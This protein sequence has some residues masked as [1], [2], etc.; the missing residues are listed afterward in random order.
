[1]P[2]IEQQTSPDGGNAATG[3]VFVGIVLT[4]LFAGGIGAVVA[5]RPGEQATSPAPGAD[6]A[7]PGRASQASAATPSLRRAASAGLAELVG[8]RD[9]AL[10]RRDAALLARVYTDGCAN[11]RYDQATIIQLLRARQRWL[12]LRSTVQVLHA[13]Q[14]G[15]LQ[16]TLVAAVS[17]A[18]ARLV[19]EAGRQVR[20]IPAQRR[21]LRFTMLRLPGGE[22][23]VLLGIASAGAAG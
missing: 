12:G 5:T 22:R 10:S 11:R 23:W 4:V 6:Q 21:V 8:L 17:R 15:A 14:T 20:A 16:W 19:T 1:M 2:T 13:N 7:A 18:P 9:A 3:L